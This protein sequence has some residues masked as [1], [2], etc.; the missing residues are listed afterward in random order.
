MVHEPFVP[1]LEPQPLLWVKDPVVEI[2]EIVSAVGPMLVK[3]TPC[4]GGGQVKPALHEK[5]RLAGMSRTVPFVSVIAALAD[6]LVSVIETALTL[7]L[8]LA[9]IVAGPV[10]VDAAPLAEFEGFMLPQPGEQFA[11][12]CVSVQFNP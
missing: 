9:G 10:K 12:F 3:V 7:T 4:V 1:T 5:L 6:L 2:A 8:P 11:P